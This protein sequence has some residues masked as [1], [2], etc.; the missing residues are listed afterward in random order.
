MA[1]IIIYIGYNLHSGT[2]TV[3]LQTDHYAYAVFRNYLGS[4]LCIRMSDHSGLV[5]CNV[6]NLKKTK[7]KNI[8]QTV[9]NYL[10][11]K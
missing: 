5:N 10:L 3:A 11:D 8:L 1:C 7:R 9:A 6:L 4:V 2:S